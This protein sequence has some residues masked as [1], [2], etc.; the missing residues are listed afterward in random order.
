MDGLNCSP[1]DWLLA[2]VFMEPCRMLTGVSFPT[3]NSITAYPHPV[4]LLPPR[5]QDWG[6]TDTGSLQRE[7]NHGEG[8]E[9]RYGS[10]LYVSPLLVTP[11]PLHPC[12]ALL[13]ESMEPVKQRRKGGDGWE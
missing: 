12:P 9:L 2:V 11:L 13:S 6:S 1:P 8:G 5:P 10:I 3:R 4:T 7:S